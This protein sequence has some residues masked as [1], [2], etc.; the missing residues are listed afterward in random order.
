MGSHD[1]DANAIPEEPTPN[2]KT[3]NLQEA[4]LKLLAQV[5][6]KGCK[7][8]N[9]R[10]DNEAS[11]EYLNMLEKQVLTMKLVPLHNHSQNLAE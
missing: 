6:Q 9:M 5:K 4:M 3:E 8:T 2:R 11:E 10:L 7:P 1:Y